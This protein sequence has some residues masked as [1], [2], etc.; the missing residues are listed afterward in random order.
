MA[1]RNFIVVVGEDI[2]GDFQFGDNISK[3]EGLLYILENGGKIVDARTDL[4]VSIG[5]KYV[6]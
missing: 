3:F 5:D 4:D 1:I 2:A 6:G